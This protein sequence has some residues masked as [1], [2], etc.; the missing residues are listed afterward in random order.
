MSFSFYLD[1]AL[2]GRQILALTSYSTIKGNI[3]IVV[4]K[5]VNPSS[6]QERSLFFCKGLVRLNPSDALSTSICL[7][8][9]VAARHL[10][11]VGLL[12]EVQDPIAEISNVLAATDVNG[13]I[14]HTDFLD[15]ESIFN[16]SK[17]ISC[18][19][20]SAALIATNTRF[21]ESSIVGPNA[22]IGVTGLGFVD[23]PNGEHIRVPHLG[24]VELGRQVVIGAGSVLVR[25]Q[26]SDTVIMDGVRLGNLVNIGHNCFIG[27]NTVISSGSVIGGGC[28]LGKDVE[29]GVGVTVAPK[30]KIGDGAF[31][32]AG[33]VVLRNVKPNV[34]VSGNPA[35]VVSR[36]NM[37]G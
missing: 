36:G 5:V 31:V 32:T 13:I 17:K 15:K 34:T 10:P 14:F 11:Q 1:Q 26:F 18:E 4:D 19:I 12:V 7:A 8:S 37:S 6:V 33:S 29:L 2:T 22:Q 21:G 27:S 16:L 23:M 9:S 28:V 3:D 20:D 25:G 30:V 24:R 35:V